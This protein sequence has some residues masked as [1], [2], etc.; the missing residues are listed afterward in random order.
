MARHP[1]SP[2]KDATPDALP[3]TACSVVVTRYPT[4]CLGLDYRGSQFFWW[5]WNLDDMLEKTDSLGIPRAAIRW[6]ERYHDGDYRDP[7]NYKTRRWVTRN[8]EASRDE[9][10]AKS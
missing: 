2:P 5:C 4:G 10:G 8:T 7:A 6:Q 1:K 9:G 3:S